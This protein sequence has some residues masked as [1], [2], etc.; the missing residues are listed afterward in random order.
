MQALAYTF[1][2]HATALLSAGDV[3][4]LTDPVLGN[5]LWGQPRRSDAAIA[6]QDLPALSAILI[7]HT[8]PDHL[9]IASFRYI[10]SDAP[11]IMPVGTARALHRF[12]NNPIIELSHWI[13][14]QI[15]PS[16][17]ITAVPVR[18]CG[19]RWIP[20]LAYHTTNAYVV[21]LAGRRIYYCGDS[22]YG[23]HF[24]EVGDLGAIDLACLPIHHWTPDWFPWNR[25]LSAQEWWQATSDL[26]AARVTPT[27]WGSFGHPSRDQRALEHLKQTGID[28]GM[29][30]HWLAA[31]VNRAIAF[32]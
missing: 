17:T 22:S 32:G 15:S 28:K 14:H 24:R 26:K 10:P 16:L 29:M 5:R 27:H 4:V 23:T 7:T 9:N 13:P 18:H 11:V 25:A 6:P 8:H 19:G 30:D 20:G 1:L 12:V 21:E 3:H 31:D 2:G